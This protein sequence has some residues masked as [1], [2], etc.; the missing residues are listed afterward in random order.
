MAVC[1]SCGS[2]V[3][4]AASFCTSCGRRMPSSNQAATITVTR[5][6]CSACG[7]P[8]DPDFAFCTNCGQR[9]AAQT[10]AEPTSSPA[11]EEPAKTAAATPSTVDG[12]PVP[13]GPLASDA[14]PT[15]AAP[16]KTSSTAACRSCGARLEPESSFCTT[17]GQPTSGGNTMAAPPPPSAEPQAPLLIKSA[18]AE[19][20]KAPI[21]AETVI[22]P[23]AP[24][25]T[26]PEAAAPQSAP[27]SPPQI[28][29]PIYATPTDY[30]PGQPG[31]SAFR[32][33]ALILLLIIV[34]GAFGAWYFWGVE[35]VIVCSPPDVRVFLDDKELQPSSYGRYVVPHLSRQT[36][37]LKV[38]R[39]GF[40]DTL[41]RLDFSMASLHE[42][43][44]IKLV[45]SRQ[46]RPSSPR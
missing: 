26:V 45:P 11:L 39:P 14:P 28:A 18:S 15:P 29:P 41:Q 42:W 46:L 37:L 31:G 10:S 44:N 25:A 23:P 7:A 38:Q 6:I 40:A 43:V 12:P 32:T 27:P 2:E 3:D 13:A 16:S 17:C 22:V 33:M 5:P 4:E 35:T 9:I 20:A 34:A 36:H 8:V 19:P 30:P 21:A 1:T 24:S